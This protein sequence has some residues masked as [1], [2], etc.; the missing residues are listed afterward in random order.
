[1]EI[2]F[3]PKHGV[4]KIKIN[5]GQNTYDF[6]PA[7]TAQTAQ[8]IEKTAIS[9]ND[10][11]ERVVG[12]KG[13][14]KYDGLTSLGLITLDID[15][16]PEGGEYV[17]LDSQ[18]IEQEE[19]PD[20]LPEPEHEIVIMQK[21]APVCQEQTENNM[22]LL[23]IIAGAAI[24]LIII[25]NII[26]FSCCRRSVKNNQEQRYNDGNRYDNILTVPDTPR[27]EQK[28]IGSR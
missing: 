2:L 9:F 16:E 11:E 6:G 10:E 17:P 8:E 20:M 26:L 21:A 14:W 18:P 22:M 3:L 7:L 5:D 13:T 27:E 15:C 23:V 19:V 4:H 28:R 12:L 25:L 1:M 24:V